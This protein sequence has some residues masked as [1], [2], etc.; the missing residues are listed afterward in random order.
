MLRD[1]T[2]FEE[3]NIYLEGTGSLVLDRKYKIA[4]AALS[5]RTN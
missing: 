2:K 3:G 1:Y 5:Q 4:Y